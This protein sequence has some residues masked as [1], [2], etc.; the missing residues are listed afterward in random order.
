VDKKGFGV[1]NPL[2][3]AVTVTYGCYIRK[4]GAIGSFERIGG[5][6]TEADLDAAIAA[7]HRLGFEVA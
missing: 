7:F 6:A 2:D 4:A 3:G 5:F 1:T